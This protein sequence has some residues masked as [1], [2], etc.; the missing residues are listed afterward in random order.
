MEALVFVIIGA[1][2]FTQAW[3]LLRLI[4]T[5]VMGMVAAT[6]ALALGALVVWQPV[7]PVTAV[8]GG[9]LAT[10]ILV[11]VIYC[12]AL[13]GIGLWG[14]DPRALGLYS[15][16]LAILMLALVGYFMLGFNPAAVVIS[17][18]SGVVCLILTV[19]FGLLFFLLAPPFR[20]IQLIVSWF[21]LVGSI[22]VALVGIGAFLNI[23]DL[24]V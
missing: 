6:G 14:F 20:R 3:N 4:D 2:L 21:Y 7:A 22:L 5:K 12:A 13:A 10:L 16:F 15:I 24:T 1:V 23:I 19:L 17:T 8:G 18:L 9:V 11:A